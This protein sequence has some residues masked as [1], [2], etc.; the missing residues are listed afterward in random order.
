MSSRRVTARHRD[1]RNRAGLSQ[2]RLA[3]LMGYKGSSSIQRYE[4]DEDYTERYFNANYVTKLADALEGK[5][6][7]PIM[8]DE[9][10]ELGGLTGIEL[11]VS[12]AKITQVPIVSWVECGKFTQTAEPLEIG[13]IDRV[14]EVATNKKTLIALDV[15]GTSINRVASEGSTLIVDYA[16]KTLVNNKYF[17]V[18]DGD[19]ATCKKYKQDPPRFEPDS[20]EEHDTIFPEAEIEVVGRVIQVVKEL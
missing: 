5:G 16:D 19:T 8:R 6:V 20:T 17:V 13:R 1:L 4:S 9:V 10:L 3:H 12:N 7:P 11:K 2:K 14:V 18:K 15:V